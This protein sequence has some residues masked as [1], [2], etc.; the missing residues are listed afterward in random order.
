MRVGDRVQLTKIVKLPEGRFDRPYLIPGTAGE[1]TRA[2]LST[3]YAPLFE[4]HFDTVPQIP[5]QDPIDMLVGWVP[6]EYLEFFPV[7]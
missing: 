2:S 1:I 6:Q 7:E 3:E 4:I 5:K